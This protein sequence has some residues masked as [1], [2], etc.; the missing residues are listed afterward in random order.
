[1]TQIKQL[2]LLAITI[3]AI[4]NIVPTQAQNT[5]DQVAPLDPTVLS[6]IRKAPFSELFSLESVNGDRAYAVKD[7]DFRS[8]NK[9]M[10]VTTL[11]GDIPEQNVLQLIVRYCIPNLTLANEQ[12]YLAELIVA[13]GDQV[14]FSL[15]QDIARTQAN[16]R[17][18]STPQ[19]VPTYFN[20]PFYDPYF[21][22][23]YFDHSY[24][25][26][27]TISALEC[28]FGGNRFDLTQVKDAIAQLPDRT[29]DLRLVFS[30]GVVEN[31]R[32]GKKTIQQIKQLPSISGIQ[33]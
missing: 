27:S 20:N 19:H 32:L 24:S 5:Q 3:G 25:P 33:Q 31:W 30:N 14:L 1:M 15:N 8:D 12:A 26:A 2:C 10:S 28:S 22:P 4:F 21:N 29:L 16:P 9:E 23:F 11:W 17:Q 7:R 18:V 6:E 13:D